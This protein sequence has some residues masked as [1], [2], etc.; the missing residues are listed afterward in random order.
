LDI[1]KIGEHD[2]YQEGA[3]YLLKNQ[4]RDGIWNQATD[5]RFGEGAVVDTCFAILFLKKA[6]PVLRTKIVKTGGDDA[7]EEGKDK[8]EEKDKGKE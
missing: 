6:T 4:Q 8:P 3:E 5:D 7:K 2:W 1:E